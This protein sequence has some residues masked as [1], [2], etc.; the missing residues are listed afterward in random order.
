MA[1]PLLFWYPCPMPDLDKHSPDWPPLSDFRPIPAAKRS[2]IFGYLAFRSASSVI[3][4]EAIVITNG[5]GRDNIVM[6]DIPQLAKILGAH[7]ITKVPFHKLVAPFAKQLFQDWEDAELLRLVLSWAGSWAPRFVRGSK[8]VL[9]NHAFGT[10]MD[11]NAPWNPLSKTPALVGDKGSVRE[12]VEIANSNGF[13]W[14]GHFGL[15]G[16]TGGWRVDGMHFEFADTTLL[17]PKDP[18]NPY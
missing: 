15:L 5:W 1:A 7:G 13:F 10:A 4:P 11:L 16:S 17:E 9:S 6:V 14:G 8:S 2:E 18:D 12:L 3:D